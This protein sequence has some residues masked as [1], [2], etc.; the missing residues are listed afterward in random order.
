MNLGGNLD[1]NLGERPTILLHQR[2][3][4]RQTDGRSINY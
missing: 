2:V 3:T 1:V 4:D